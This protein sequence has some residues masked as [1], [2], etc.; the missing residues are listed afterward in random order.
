MELSEPMAQSILADLMRGDAIAPATCRRRSERIVVSE[1]RQLSMPNWPGPNCGW[2]LL[3]LYPMFW[4]EPVIKR[5]PDRCRRRKR[6]K[7]ARP[8]RA[9]EWPEYEMGGA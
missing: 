3:K 6:V 9:G 7:L 2:R 1:T 8:L 4:P 5:E